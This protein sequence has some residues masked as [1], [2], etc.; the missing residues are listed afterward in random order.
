MDNKLY[1]TLINIGLSENEAKVYLNAL[2]LG[3]TTILKISRASEVKRTTIYNVIESLKQLGLIRIEQKGWKTY[4][5]AENPERL[6]GIMERK[7]KELK[8]NLDE[9][10]AL[11]N[12]EGGSSLIKYYEGSEAIKNIHLDLLDELKIGD[13]YFVISDSVKWMSVDQ[14]FFEKFIEKRS[15]KKLNNKLLLQDSDIA[16]AYKKNEKVYNMKIK[17]FPQNIK[18][19]ALLTIT[20]S[21]IIIHQNTSPIMAMVIENQNI[22]RFHK[23]IFGFMWQAV[24]D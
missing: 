24:K 10:K 8:E 20:P 18:L 16:R 9:F 12:I 21:K 5:A 11:Y 15:R 13:D 17:I 1:K 7:R 19:S 22:I 3:K 14:K 6:E 2:S 23:E 4:Y